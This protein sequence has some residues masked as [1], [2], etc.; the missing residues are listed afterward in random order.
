[1][2]LLRAFATDF[3]ES[4]ELGVAP[5]A[6]LLLGVAID[7]SETRGLGPNTRKR[8]ELLLAVLSICNIEV[9]KKAIEKVEKDLKSELNLLAALGSSSIGLKVSQL[10][11]DMVEAAFDA[12]RLL[13]GPGT[14]TAVFWV[15]SFGKSTHEVPWSRFRV[16]FANHYPSSSDKDLKRLQFVARRPRIRDGRPSS[17]VD[18]ELRLLA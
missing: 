3:E 16:N 2:D 12:R 18:T 6:A 14:D 5:D 9:D 11:E 15:S 13:G 4:H 7:A 10:H 17:C 1:M 8:L